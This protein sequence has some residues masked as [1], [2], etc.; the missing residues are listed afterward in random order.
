MTDKANGPPPPLRKQQ[1]LDPSIFQLPVEKMRSGYYTD[2]YFLY[3]RDV[4]LK[5]GHRH[6][7]TMQVF[8]K[9]SAYL[10][11][12]DEAI[13][14]LKLC[15]TE[16]FSW[17]DIEVHALRDGD[18]VGPWETS[19]LITGPGWR[20]MIAGYMSRIAWLLDGMTTVRPG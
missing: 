13:A 17:S 8:Q 14:I 7:V 11:G 5:E 10:G 12:V 15:L 19:M 18:L 9:K 1:R 6:T 2:K 4:L 16:G 20:L 3:T